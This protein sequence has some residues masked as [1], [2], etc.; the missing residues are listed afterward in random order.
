MRLSKSAI[1]AF[2]FCPYSFWVKYIQKFKTPPNEAMLRGT[3]FHDFAEKFFDKCD[4]LP[5]ERWEEFVDETL[6]ED[7]QEYQR[8][9]IQKERARYEKLLDEGKEDYFIPVYRE[10]HINSTDL[11]LHGYIDRIDCNDRHKKT[12][13]LVEYKTSKKHKPADVKRELS[14]YRM[15]W[16]SEMSEEGTITQLLIINPECQ[17]Y[18]YYKISD[19]N[20]NAARNLMI[21]LREAIAADDFPRPMNTYKCQ[22]CDL[23]KL[24]DY[25]TRK[26]GE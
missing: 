1:E 14:Y 15:L 17:E 4:E 5:P 16:D 8:W 11:K 26:R 25:Q 10:V 12:F 7:E 3:R 13:T 22:Y 9:F 6:K 24:Y 2:G 18:A 21:K 20:M 19:R 23:C